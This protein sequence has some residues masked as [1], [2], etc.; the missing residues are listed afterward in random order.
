MLTV[1]SVS[2]NCG[3]LILELNST[4]ENEKPVRE[5]ETLVDDV[6]FYY[7]VFSNGIVSYG[8]YIGDRWW[9]S[10]PECINDAFKLEGTDLE[11][12]DISCRVNFR[13]CGLLKSKFDELDREFR[14]TERHQKLLEAGAYSEKELETKEE[15][16]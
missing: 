4:E 9:S 6:K 12:A 16:K 7:K 5:A 14:I 10:R 8:C 13:E 15:T 3:I 1:K 2:N 11:L